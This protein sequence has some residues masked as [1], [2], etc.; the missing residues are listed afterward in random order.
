MVAASTSTVAV[1]VA[2]GQSSAPAAPSNGVTY[3]QENG[4]TYRETRYTVGH[5]VT[6]TH[7]E[8]QQHTVYSQ[9]PTTTNRD[10]VRTYHVPV[11]EY[12]SETYLKGRWN[13][14]TTPYMAERIRPV[15]Y[16]QMRTDVVQVPV[17]QQVVVPQTVT[18]H[19]PVTTH[20]VVNEE[21]ISR[22][23]VSGPA[24][25]PTL[26]PTSQPTAIAIAPPPASSNVTV[27]GISN[28]QQD[29]PRVGSNY[30]WRPATT[31]R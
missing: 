9:V 18:V 23:A 3:Y 13:P 30:Q 25:V 5:P 21:H 14:F 22:V 19:V 31:L 1:D 4:V 27:G 24:G 7:L 17:Q 15:T 10:V 2:F 28:L 16:W 6:Q 8:P 26:S 12:R 20:H 11:T 29:P